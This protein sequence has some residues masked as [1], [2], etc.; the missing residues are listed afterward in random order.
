MKLRGYIL[1]N[2]GQPLQDVNVLLPEL[3][4]LDGFNVGTTTDANGYY[5]IDNGSI[6]LLTKV[7]ISIVGFKKVT[8]TVM[9]IGAKAIQ[10]QEDIL[11]G[12]E[13]VV[14]GKKSSSWSWFWWLLAAGTTYKIVK[15]YLPEKVV[16]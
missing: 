9:E 3:K 10:L 14:T 6:S 7:E 4:T 5:S 1:D 15:S 11:Q 16:L 13:V 2:N 12:G 8:A